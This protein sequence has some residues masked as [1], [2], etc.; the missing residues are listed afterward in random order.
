MSSV[1]EAILCVPVL[2]LW[3]GPLAL[4]AVA[5]IHA[6]IARLT[7]GSR[8]DAP[9]FDRPSVSLHVARLRRA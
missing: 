6:A 7:T 2:L 8:H 4:A 9:R 5:L 3:F 1:L